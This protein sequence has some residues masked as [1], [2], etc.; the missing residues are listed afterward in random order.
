MSDLD[1]LEKK[2]RKN[3]KNFDK[4]YSAAKARL[5]LAI[6][7]ANE[8]QKAGITQKE[9]ADKLK[10]TQSVISRIENGRQN[11]SLDMLQRIAEALGKS[12]VIISF[13]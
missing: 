1:L 7:I 5:E 4:K 13:K 9:F 10:T 3:I 6:K 2:L 12:E 11:I 8:R